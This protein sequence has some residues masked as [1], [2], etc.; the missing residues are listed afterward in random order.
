[1]TLDDPLT[2]EVDKSHLV[3]SGRPLYGTPIRVTMNG[4]TATL[5]L[6]GDLETINKPA[7]YIA[8]YS[9]GASLVDKPAKQRLRLPNG[10]TVERKPAKNVVTFKDGSRFVDKPVK[11]TFCGIS[12]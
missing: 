1:M 11:T 12:I 5:P 10:T 2:I 4:S 9:N 7:K 6:L 3:V 8:K